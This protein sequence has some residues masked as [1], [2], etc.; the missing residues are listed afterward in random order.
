MHA[1]SSLS[2][3]VR[4]DAV[5]NSR[6]RR[7]ASLIGQTQSHSS[8]LLAKAKFVQIAEVVDKSHQSF[9]SQ[10]VLSCCCRRSYNNAFQSNARLTGTGNCLLGRWLRLPSALQQ[11]FPTAH[12]HAPV[13]LTGAS[14][15]LTR[16]AN[17][18]SGKALHIFRLRAAGCWRQR[19][20]NLALQPASQRDWC[21]P[22]VCSC[23]L[24]SPQPFVQ[25]F[26]RATWTDMSAGPRLHS[27]Q[28]SNCR[29]AA[30][31]AS[32]L[33]AWPDET[34]SMRWTSAIRQMCG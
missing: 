2:E 4:R 9:S 15:H 25:W 18:A 30:C 13:L 31:H 8:H 17:R 34:T 19:H 7:E 11:Q 6:M 20:A 12:P 16:R 21:T 1:C 10:A 26:A 24:R 3:G 5:G 27:A 14:A 32:L 23:R 29:M 28:S 33:N 22:D